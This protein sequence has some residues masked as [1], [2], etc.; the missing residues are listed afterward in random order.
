MKK[1][2]LAST[3]VAAS[4]GVAA[5]QGITFS[6]DAGFGLIYNSGAPNIWMPSMNA[7]LT[8]NMDAETDGGLMFGAEFSVTASSTGVGA[9]IVYVE[10]GFGRFEVGNVDNGVQAVVG[11]IA[12]PGWA[13]PGVDNHAEL[14]RNSSTANALY[15]GTF[16]DFSVAL[17]G[18]LVPMAVGGTG[19]WAIGGGYTFADYSI[20]AGYSST[21]GTNAYHLGAGA[22]FGDFALH[23][24]YSSTTGLVVNGQSYGVDASYTMGAIKVTAA[25]GAVT[26]GGVTGSGVGLGVDYD[27]GGGA[28]LQAGVANFN[29]TALPLVFAGT[30]VAGNTTVSLG[31]DMSF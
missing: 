8:I 29:A 12:D 13:G 2:L 6:G 10:G 5:A 1:I 4:A 31:I 16:G 15:T 25:Y 7:S 11:G 9:A 26:A 18:D 17:S 24:L 14:L 20:A 19:D 3:I 30:P 22:T 28:K 27:L 21:L 23:A